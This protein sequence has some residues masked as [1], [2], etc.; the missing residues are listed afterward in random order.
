MNLLFLGDVV[1]K[2]GC[3]AVCEVLPRLIDR[4]FIDFTV[5]NAE[6]VED[7]AGLEIGLMNRLLAAGANVLTSGNHAYRRSEIIPYLEVEPMFL[8]PANFPGASPGS[9]WTIGNTASGESV[10]VINLI[11]R[12]FM[13]P[14]DCPFQVVDRVLGQIRDK[15]TTV[16]VDMHA[17]ATSEK[18]AMGWYLDGRVSA[19]LGT[20]THV[21]T[22]DERILPRGTAYLSDAGMCGPIDSV[23]GARP[24]DGIRRFHTAVPTKLKVA[25]GPTIVS[26]AIVSVNEQGQALSIRRVQEKVPA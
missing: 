7:G 2:P 18:Q 12:V 13:D 17:E 20:H 6:N 25:S 16:V 3:R 23:I 22:A 21:Q 5:V 11:G 4:E 14:S 24:E 10:A 1:G 9:G 19:V 8:R 15:A 26:G